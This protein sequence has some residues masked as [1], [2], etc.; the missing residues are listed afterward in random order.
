MF[1]IK[2]LINNENVKT[3]EKK[4]NMRIIEYVNDL[5]VKLT[6]SSHDA[7]DLTEGEHAA[8]ERV[9]R[10]IAFI[11]VSEHGTAMI[12]SHRKICLLLL[13]YLYKLYQVATS[14]EVR[15]L[16]E[17]AVRKYVAAAQMHEVGTVRE[18]F[19]HRNDIIMRSC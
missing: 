4:G 14:F 19:R 8:V 3:L 11:L 6:Y 9:A 10:I 17:I 1:K 16:D 7:V 15:C 13:E 12:D 18:F 2:N 5:S